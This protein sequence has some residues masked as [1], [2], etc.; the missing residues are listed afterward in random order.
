M[1]EELRRRGF[2]ALDTDAEASRI[3]DDGELLWDEQKVG[4][5]LEAASSSTVFV[6][7]T[8]SNQVHFYERFDLIVLLSAPPEVMIQRVRTRTSNP[9]GRTADQQRKILADRDLF[10][11]LLR[12]RAHAEIAT[13][14]PLDDVVEQ[15]VEIA[16]T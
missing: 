15:L 5:A 16:S 13:D 1:A 7:G 12:R 11:P 9:F 2:A 14:Q 4:A 8:A 3:A 10:E 6:I